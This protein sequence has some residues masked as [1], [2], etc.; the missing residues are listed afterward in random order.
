MR[1][2]GERRPRLIGERTGTRVTA[3]GGRTMSTTGQEIPTIVTGGGVV[4]AWWDE[5]GRFHVRVDIDG[6]PNSRLIDNAVPLDISVGDQ[7]VFPPVDDSWDD[8]L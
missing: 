5:S 8:E 2:G 6:I 4:S 1:I 3:A 7:Q